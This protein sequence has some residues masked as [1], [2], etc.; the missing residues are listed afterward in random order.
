MAHKKPDKKNE[1]QVLTPGGMRPKSSV[2]HV[3]PGQMVTGAGTIVGKNK[4]K[5]RGS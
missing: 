5:R 1:E 2:H 3:K 4:G